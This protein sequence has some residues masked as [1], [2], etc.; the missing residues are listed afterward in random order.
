MDLNGRA[1][2]RERSELRPKPGENAR[3]ELES[4]FQIMLTP[5]VIRDCDAMPAVFRGEQ[6]ALN[7]SV[8]VEL[9]FAAI[10]YV[11]G[12]LTR[13]EGVRVE[14]FDRVLSTH[15]LGRVRASSKQRV[16]DLPEPNC[17]YS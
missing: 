15:T 16:D 14:H 17:D 13:P 12:Q 2:R 8:D 10:S 1:V 3:Q 6:K 5:W 4:G 7:L 9:I 11:H